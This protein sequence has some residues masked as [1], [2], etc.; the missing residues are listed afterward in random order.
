[1]FSKKLYFVVPGEGVIEREEGGKE[2][3][4]ENVNTSP[5]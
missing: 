5:S 1:M 4:I 2:R 3:D